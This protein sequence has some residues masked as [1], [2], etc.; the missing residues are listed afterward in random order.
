MNPEESKISLED[1]NSNQQDA[2]TT[3]GGPLL[4]YAGAGS[5]K[6]RVLS[7]RIAWLIE[8]RLAKGW[9]IWAVTFTRKAALEMKGRAEKLLGQKNTGVF[10]GTFHAFGS[11]FLKEYQN[12]KLIGRGRFFT[13]YDSDDQGK[14]IT[15]V[16][17]ELDINLK[18]QFMTPGLVREAISRWKDELIG[19]LE[20]L[21]TK[22]NHLGLSQNN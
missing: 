14:L 12:H 1:L 16:A 2:V 8:E 15:D 3:R 19:P 22:E 9:E 18:A 20:A 21:S 17:K 11:Q 10:L 13:I 5:G 7:Y 6:T 4:I